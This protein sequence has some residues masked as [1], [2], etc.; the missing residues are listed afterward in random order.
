[1]LGFCF[2]STDSE[3]FRRHLSKFHGVQHLEKFMAL[4]EAESGTFSFRNLD[5]NNSGDFFPMKRRKFF[6]DADDLSPT[7]KPK[8]SSFDDND[9][10][11]GG[12]GRSS[13]LKF[14]GGSDDD[15]TENVVCEVDE[16]L[17]N[18]V[19][20]DDDDDDMDGNDDDTNDAAAMAADGSKATFQCELCPTTTLTKSS[21]RRHCLR[22]HDLVKFFNSHSCSLY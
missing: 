8:E 10:G 16:N 3:N 5:K 13:P 9:V 2:V 11:D 4:F 15:A 17:F 18:N 20:D 1:M 14:D 12:D 21:M 19:D 7:K 22:S 6:G